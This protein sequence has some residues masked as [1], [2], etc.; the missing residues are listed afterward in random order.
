MAADP[1]PT[2]GFRL[3]TTRAHVDRADSA[4]RRR[5]PN[6]LTPEQ[7]TELRRLAAAAIDACNRVIATVDADG[8]P[9]VPGFTRDLV[10]DIDTPLLRTTDQEATP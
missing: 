4:R 10:I 5:L 2:A 9:R 3:A 6:G 1:S 7:D 8:H